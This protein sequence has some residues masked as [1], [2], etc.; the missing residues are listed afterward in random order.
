MKANT[1]E[2]DKLIRHSC[3]GIPM[4]VDVQVKPFD[5]VPHGNFVFGGI[6]SSLTDDD[7]ATYGGVLFMYNSS[8]VRVMAPHKRNNNR[9]KI[10][11]TGNSLIYYSE[12]M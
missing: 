9:G 6:G 8:Y 1:K 2:S 11:Y 12:L 4:K 3:N 5:D 7:Y 10:I